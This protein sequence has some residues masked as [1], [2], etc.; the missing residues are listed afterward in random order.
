[1]AEMNGK[2]NMVDVDV[3]LVRYFAERITEENFRISEKSKNGEMLPKKCGIIEN[4]LK[5]VIYGNRK[6][7]SS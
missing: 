3:C 2:I 5:G 7:N 1:M 4:I 6:E